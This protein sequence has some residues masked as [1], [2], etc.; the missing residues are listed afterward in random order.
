V[1]GTPFENPALDSSRI[2]HKTNNADNGYNVQ[3]KSC[4]EFHGHSL[5]H[6]LK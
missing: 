1:P 2:N 5:S 3:E 6:L 4:F